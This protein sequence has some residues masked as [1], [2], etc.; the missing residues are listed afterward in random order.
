MFCYAPEK[1]CSVM[2]DV[3]SY[4]REKNSST[5][6]ILSRAKED[7]SVNDVLSCGSF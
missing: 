7:W 5:K 6:Y 1:N 4:A 3:P 2:V